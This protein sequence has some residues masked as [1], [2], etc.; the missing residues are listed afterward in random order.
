MMCLRQRSWG[1][2]LVVL[3]EVEVEVVRLL[4]Y[5]MYIIST[6]RYGC[7]RSSLREY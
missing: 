5:E 1:L 6:L 2:D 7:R 3:R 4:M